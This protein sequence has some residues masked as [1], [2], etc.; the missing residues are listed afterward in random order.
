MKNLR[1]PVR[2]HASERCTG[3]LALWCLEGSNEDTIGR[4]E[5]SDG[6][7]LSE[8]LGVRKDIETA[9]RLGVGLE[10]GAH[11]LSSTAWHCGF[12]DDDLRSSRDPGD[13]TRG[14]FDIAIDKNDISTSDPTRA[15]DGWIG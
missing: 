8:E 1:D 14:K 15:R 7:S 6:G 11:R 2:V 3:I 13:L 4:E 9:S 12:L 10:D 5:V